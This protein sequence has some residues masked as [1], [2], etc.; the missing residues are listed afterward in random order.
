MNTYHVLKAFEAAEPWEVLGV[1]QNELKRYRDKRENQFISFK[2]V[3]G[4]ENT[5]LYICAK[6][7]QGLYAQLKHKERIHYLEFSSFV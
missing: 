5:L 2:R 4:V 3:P 7:S 6:G 1:Y